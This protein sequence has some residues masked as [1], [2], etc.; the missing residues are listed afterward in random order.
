MSLH[1]S[2]LPYHPRSNN[3]VIVLD[4]PYAL[5]QGTDLRG[6]AGVV[7]RAERDPAIERYLQNLSET[8]VQEL[9]KCKGRFVD[10]TLKRKPGEGPH[11][12]PPLPPEPI[13][14]ASE[15]L[16]K[17]FHSLTQATQINIHFSTATAPSF[18]IDGSNSKPSWR[19]TYAFIGN[20]TIWHSQTR[21]QNTP[22][23]VQGGT[24]FP[25]LPKEKIGIRDVDYFESEGA[26]MFL[27]YSPN[28]LFHKSPDNQNARRLVVTMDADA[29]RRIDCTRSCPFPCR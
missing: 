3:R 15:K 9:Q 2:G 10:G 4:A 25:V 27:G 26:L 18:H 13:A 24:G 29:P 28:G 1:P 8:H 23:S 16:A 11:A 17:I 12:P 20:Q 21:D 6:I 7:I 22:V 19:L 5:P 14:Q